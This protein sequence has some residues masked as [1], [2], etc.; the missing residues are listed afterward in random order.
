MEAI[1]ESPKVIQ[2]CMRI[3]GMSTKEVEALIECDLMCGIRFFDHADIYGGDGR[4]EQLFGEVLAGRPELR[5]QMIIQTKCGIREG[6]YDFSK[7]HILRSVEGSLRRLRCE[8]IDV[9]LLHRPDV[10]ME[11]EEVAEAFEQLHTSGKV[12]HFGVSNQSAAQMELLRRTVGRPIEVTQLQFGPA[13]TAM[14][15]AGVLVNTAFPGAVTRDGGALDYCRLEGIA[16]QAWSPYQ[17]GL[18]EGAFWGEER[19]RGLCE[20]LRAL[21]ERH[22]VGP[23]AAA[24]AW[25]LRHPALSQVVIGTTKEERVRDAARAG[26][27]S[28]SREEWYEVYRAAGNEVI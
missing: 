18:I 17:F 3:A 22:G 27:V 15:D 7:E 23:G 10:L 26:E 12:A 6:L 16:V 8:R 24:L 28:L 25:T 20:K 19:Y 21:G 14:V 11:P 1:F 4:C 2:G 9:L 5:E 13:W